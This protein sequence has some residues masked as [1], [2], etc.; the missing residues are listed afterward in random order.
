M[1]GTLVNIQILPHSTKNNLVFLISNPNPL[2][3]QK[4]FPE[5]WK[6]ISNIFSNAPF[7]VPGETFLFEKL[8]SYVLV[9]RE[10]S[11]LSVFVKLLSNLLKSSLSW[12]ENK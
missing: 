4:Q 8:V 5:C 1:G 3:K 9:V 12:P 7:L 11:F 6:K 2:S 10:G